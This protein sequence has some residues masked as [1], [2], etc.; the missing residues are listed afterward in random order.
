MSSPRFSVIIAVFN[1]ARTITRAIESV[2]AQTHAAHEIIVVDDGS[3]DAT[4]EQ[5]KHFGAAVT[6]IHQPNAGVAAARNAG[7]DAASGDWLAFLDADDYYYPERLQWHAELLQYHPELDFMTGDFDYVRPSGELIRRSME[8]T[9]AGR[10]LLAL[11]AGGEYRIMEGALIGEFVEKHFGDTHTLSLPRQTFQE[12][13]GYPRGIAVCE[14]VN[15]LIRLCARSRRVGVVCRPMAA[16]VIHE[17]SATRADP[18]RAQRQTLAALLPLRQSLTAAPAAIRAGLE[19]CIRQ[20]RL[21]LAYALLKAGQRGGALK[22]ALPLLK[23]RPGVASVRDVISI[24]R[25]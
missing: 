19:G 20:A 1:G 12:L 16:Y 5:V 10:K 9:P 21:D 14:D 25:G 22:A 15:L 4:A 23:D 7:V 2:L 13:G 24:A 3:T 11:A 8:S 18:L 6:Y 17:A